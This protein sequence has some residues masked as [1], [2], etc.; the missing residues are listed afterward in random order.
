MLSLDLILP[1]LLC[2]GNTDLPASSRTHQAHSTLG[3]LLLLPFCPEFSF[4]QHSYSFLHH[5]TEVSVQMSHCQREPPHPSHPNVPFPNWA[6]SHVFTTWKHVGASPWQQGPYGEMFLML[7]TLASP[8]CEHSKKDSVPAALCCIVNE[9]T[10]I[11]RSWVWA[12]FLFSPV[13][14]RRMRATVAWRRGP[15]LPFPVFWSFSFFSFV[16]P[17]LWHIFKA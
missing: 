8:S 7:L 3:P 12:W 15:P 2:S 14:C 4:L 9:V 6:V 17:S 13:T 11:Y 1:L 10:V 16:C 5:F